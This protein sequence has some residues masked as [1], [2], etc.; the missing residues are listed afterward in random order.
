IFHTLFVTVGLTSYTPYLLVG[1]VS[2]ATFAVVVYIYFRR[3]VQ[4]A[5]ACIAALSIVW[6]STAQLNVLFPLLLNFSIPMAVTV[7]IWMCLDR[8]DVRFDLAAAGFLA[9][10]LACGGVGLV[11]V[12]AVATELLVRRAPIKRWFPFVVPVALWCLWYAAY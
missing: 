6:F 12:A 5:L 10:A 7:L 3:R 9:I 11:P 8:N 1:L 2:Y 4:P